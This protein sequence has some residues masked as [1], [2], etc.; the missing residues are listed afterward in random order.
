MFLYTFFITYRTERHI[1]ILCLI[2]SL[3]YMI[4]QR[5]LIVHSAVLRT[6]SD[7]GC[8]IPDIQSSQLPAVYKQIQ[9][10]C[11]THGTEI[12]GFLPQ[13]MYTDFID[14]ASQISCVLVNE[15]NTFCLHRSKSAIIISRV[16]SSPLSLLA[17]GCHS[18]PFR[19]SI[20]NLPNISSVNSDLLP[21]S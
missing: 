14:M 4:V 16:L 15:A 11:T 17:I 7:T 2:T 20:S 8:R 9:L 6:E 21:A 19:Y 10:V 18:P 1:P 13:F 5:T 3:L 12:I